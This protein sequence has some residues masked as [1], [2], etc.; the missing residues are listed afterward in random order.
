VYGD[1]NALTFQ[2]SRAG[3]FV[4]S[5]AFERNRESSTPSRTAID[6]TSAVVMD[7]LVEVVYHPFGA[8]HFHSYACGSATL[9]LASILKPVGQDGTIAIPASSFP[10]L[11]VTIAVNGV[12]AGLPLQDISV[13]E[14]QWHANRLGAAMFLQSANISPSQS[15]FKT[16]TLWMPDAPG[17][18]QPKS[19]FRDVLTLNSV[20]AGDLSEDPRIFKRTVTFSIRP[21]SI[22]TPRAYGGWT[23]QPGSFQPPYGGFYRGAFIADEWPFPATIPELNAKL[24]TGIP[25]TRISCLNPDGLNTAS[26]FSPFSPVMQSPINNLRLEYQLLGARADTEAHGVVYNDFA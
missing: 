10:W 14:G 12:A 23:A 17:V 16:E 18:V 24:G 11:R 15:E 6:I 9:G 1:V 13:V 25:P 2:K 8:G 21:S 4:E 19:D 7:D 22:L 3:E 5:L 20:E 26:I